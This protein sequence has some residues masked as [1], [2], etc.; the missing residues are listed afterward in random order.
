MDGSFFFFSFWKIFNT[1]ENI[2]R[3]SILKKKRMVK[4]L[5]SIVIQLPVRSFIPLSG[6]FCF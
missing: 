3:P 1:N 4:I 6:Y 2:Y 5:A